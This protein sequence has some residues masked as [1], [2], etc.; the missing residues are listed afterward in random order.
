LKLWLDAG[1]T[2]SYSGIGSIWTNLISG[3]LNGQL[4]NSPIYRDNTLNFNGSNMYVDIGPVNS[5]A[6]TSITYSV[7][8]KVNSLSA[9]QTLFWDDDGEGGGDCW[10][11]IRPDGKVESQRDGDGFG[12]MV[13]SRTV[14]ANTWYNFAFVAN[15]TTTPRKA[16]YFNGV[17]DA[18]NNIPI[19]SRAGISYLSLA[20]KTPFPSEPEYHSEWLNGTLSNAMVY[21]RS[22]TADEITTNF[23]ALRGRYGI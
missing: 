1:Q 2:T 9:N 20:V 15:G 12:V 14:V 23:N 4:V 8:F 16:F 10:I 3:G 6:S 22:L 11:T 13:S 7:W 18:T 17:L 5:S 21:H 19:T